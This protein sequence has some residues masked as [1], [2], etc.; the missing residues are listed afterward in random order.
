M[1]SRIL[2]VYREAEF[3]PG[4][5]ADDAAIL[6]A[7]L[8]HLRAQG[9]EI[10]AL[11]VAGFV[12]TAPDNFDMVLAMCQGA[13]ALEALAACEDRGVLVINSPGAIRACYRD[14]LGGALERAAVPTPAGMLVSTSE[15]LEPELIDAFD[16]STGVFVKRGD[17]HAL[18][19]EDVLKINDPA[20]IRVELGRFAARGIKSAYLQQAVGG[21]VVKFYGVSGGRYF[22]PVIDGVTLDA[23]LQRALADAANRAASALGLEIW[24]GDAIVNERGFTIIDFNDWPSFSRVRAQAAP[25]IARRCADLQNKR[26]LQSER[27]KGASS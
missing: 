23:S 25:A 1:T 15:S 24:G 16:F 13:H 8:D 3:S 27:N 10:A 9:N 21:I 2:G 20:K 22:A 12:H 14:R 11:D 4:K 6:D 18:T 26:N 19:A 5:V 7:A 17:L